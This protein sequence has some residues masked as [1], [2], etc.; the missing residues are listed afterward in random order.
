MLFTTLNLTPKGKQLLELKG[1]FEDI[2][3]G[4]CLINT[5]TA[6]KVLSDPAAVAALTCAGSGI[7]NTASAHFGGYNQVGNTLQ[8]NIRCHAPQ[9]LS[10]LNG[11]L[12]I[13]VMANEDIAASTDAETGMPVYKVFTK[14]DG[15]VLGYADMIESGN[16]WTSQSTTGFNFS[17]VIT[18]R[19]DKPSRCNFKE[20]LSF[21]PVSG[22]GITNADICQHDVAFPSLS[23]HEVGETPA[24]APSALEARKEPT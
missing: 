1:Q 19:G 6:L 10:N 21:A 13:V 5:T 12:R 17:A 20:V 8:M 11:Q 15:T 22:A 3:I 18:V 14:Q 24:E 23:S 7:K 2:K 4:R 9:D 16:V